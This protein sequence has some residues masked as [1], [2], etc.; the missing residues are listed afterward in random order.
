MIVAMNYVTL[1]CMKEDKAALLDRLQS[2]GLV[3]L[4]Q[5]EGGQ[6]PSSPAGEQVQRMERLMQQLKPYAPKRGMLAGLPEESAQALQQVDQADQQAVDKMEQ[7]LQQLQQ[8]R[9]RLEEQSQQAAQLAPWEALDLTYA[10]L[11]QGLGYTRFR[12]GI[13]SASAWEAFPGSRGRWGIPASAAP[14]PTAICWRR[15]WT[16]RTWTPCRKAGNR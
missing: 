1:A 6:S 9:R 16:N 5:P 4:S 11:Q 8:H 2:S 13:L 14:A 10:Q 3:M 12:L 7:L 15:R